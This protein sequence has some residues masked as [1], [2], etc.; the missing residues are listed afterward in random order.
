MLNAVFHFLI[1]GI[2]MEI[3]KFTQILQQIPNFNLLILGV[4]II[5][6]GLRVLFHF[7]RLRNNFSKLYQ[8]EKRK[9]QRRKK[10]EPPSNMDQRKTYEKRISCSSPPII[11]VTAKKYN[12]AFEKHLFLCFISFAFNIGKSPFNIGPNENIN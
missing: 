3:Y 10:D 8:P 11:Y 12:R 7:D 6:R 5:A 1:D 2:I 4:I 9:E